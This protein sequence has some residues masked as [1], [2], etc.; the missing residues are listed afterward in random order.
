EGAGGPSTLLLAH[1]DT[2]WPL[3][4]LEEMPFRREGDK[5]FGPGTIDMKAG[6][7]TALTAVDLVPATGRTLSG[8]VTL[9][10]TSDEEQGSAASKGLI[11]ELARRHDRVLVLEPGRDDGAL[12]VGRKG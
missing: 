2:V 6:I 3:G 5:L 7:V 8:D 12:K 10:V 4:T 9:L 11:E 1:L